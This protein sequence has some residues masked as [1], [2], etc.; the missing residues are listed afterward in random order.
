MGTE[1][2]IAIREADLGPVI[3]RADHVDR[4]IEVNKEIF[5]KL[6]PMVQEFVLC[7]EVCHLT[8][9]EWDEVAT[10]QLASQLFLDRSADAPDR[11]RRQR[12]L[13]YLDGNGGFSN[14]AWATLISSVIGLGTTIYGIVRNRNQGWYSWD[15]ATQRSNLNA[16]LTQAFEASRKTSTESASQIFWAQM[17]GYT[18]KDGSLDEFLGRSEN[19]WVRPAIA[20]YEQAY[21]FGFSEV[22]PIDI[23]AFPVAMIA[24][25]LVAGIAVFYIIKKLKK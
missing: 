25:G 3:A 22:T 21:G 4:A 7:H 13:S 18:T 5:Y 23:T 12:F 1:E 16:M 2:K 24:I 11:D 8:H 17:Q 15:S 19:A 6:P 14:F 9:D 10:N 20:N